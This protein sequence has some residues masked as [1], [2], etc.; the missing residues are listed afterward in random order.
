MS[1]LRK[2]AEQALHELDRL[3]ERSSSEGPNL[4]PA[5]RAAYALRTAL[6]APEQQG[7]PVPTNRDAIERAYTSSAIDVARNPVGSRDWVLFYEGWTRALARVDDLERDGRVRALALGLGLDAPIYAHP[8][9]LAAPQQAEPPQRKPLTWLKAVVLWGHRS[10]G[11]TNEEIV[12]YARVIEAEHGI[13][14][15]ALG[16]GGAT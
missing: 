3:V 16:K 6:D 15:D 1:D 5:R 4:G 7:E 12:S 8:P 14:D 13:H 9:A 2:A 11:P 10:D